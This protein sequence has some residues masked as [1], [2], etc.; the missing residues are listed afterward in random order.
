MKYKK[1]ILAVKDDNVL[2]KIFRDGVEVDKQEFNCLNTSFMI[3]SVKWIRENRFI[4][5]HKWADTYI[6][7]LKKYEE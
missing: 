7:Q 2:A 4:K 3:G 1:E 5:A 6:E